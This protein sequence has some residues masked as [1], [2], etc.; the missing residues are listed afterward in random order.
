MSENMACVANQ[1]TTYR[2]DEQLFIA[3][4]NQASV[5]NTFLMRLL[6]PHLK[7]L[8]LKKNDEA[9]SEC[10]NSFCPGQTNARWQC[11]L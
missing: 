3:Q 2:T 7:F 11:C 10:C 1:L 4:G 5:K 6:L 8:L 9:A